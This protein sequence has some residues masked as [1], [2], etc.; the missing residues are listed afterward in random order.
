MII[1]ALTY[2]FYALLYIILFIVLV[3]LVFV[4]YYGCKGVLIGFEIIADD[5]IADVICNVPNTET[6]PKITEVTET[7]SEKQLRWHKET[8]K[9]NNTGN[10]IYVEAIARFRKQYG[11]RENNILPNKSNSNTKSIPTPKIDTLKIHYEEIIAEIDSNMIAYLTN[12]DKFTEFF[13]KIRNFECYCTWYD[14]KG[15]KCQKLEYSYKIRDK[16][17][18]TLGSHDIKCYETTSIGTESIYSKISDKKRWVIGFSTPYA[19]YKLGMIKYSMIDYTYP[20][21]IFHDKEIESMCSNGDDYRLD[22]KKK[23]KSNWDEYQDYK[24]SA[25]ENYEELDRNIKN[26]Q[27]TWNDA[28]KERL[29]SQKAFWN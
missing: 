23:D 25:R 15:C 4:C 11:T 13:K 3:C 7:F 19:S 27:D 18:Y 1:E 17:K 26:T 24:T 29:E 8:L 12:K 5:T 22:N 9:Y 21:I 16:I 2:I 28:Q 10:P 14:D 20:C 6:K